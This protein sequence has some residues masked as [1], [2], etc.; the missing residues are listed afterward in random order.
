MESAQP[1]DVVRRLA[2]EAGTVFPSLAELDGVARV[3]QPVEQLLSAAYFDTDDLD[4]ARHGVTLRRRTGGT[5][6][7]WLLRLPAGQGAPLDLRRP[8]GR[9]TTTVPT[10]LASAVRALVRGRRLA[11]VA[12]VSTRR[13]AYDLVT[14]DAVV[15]A[16]VSDDQ[17][18][19]ERLHGPTQSEDWREWRVQPVDGHRDLVDLV[20]RRLLGVGAAPA[21]AASRLARA[22]GDAIPA[23]PPPPSRKKL[24]AGSAAGVMLAYLTEHIGELQRHDIGLRAE[25]GTAVHQLRIA[26]RRIRSTLQTYGPLV[27]SRSVDPIID[28]LRWLGQSLSETRDAQVLGQRLSDLA[29][30]EPAE[31][32][33]GPV[34]RRIDDELRTAERTGLEHGLETLDSDRYVRLLDA[35]DALVASP[36]LASAAEAPA[37]KVLPDLLQREGKRLRRAVKRIA[38]AT[39]PDLH[40]AALHEARKKAKRLRYAAESAAPVFGKRAEALAAAVKDVQDA[41]GEHQDAVMA[42][43]RLREYGVR[44][45]AAGENGFTFGRLHALEQARA[46]EAERAFDA[47]WRAMPGGNLRRWIGT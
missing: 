29:A 35:L 23:P 2:V 13:L 5:D 39:D 25:G 22:L 14:E 17:V 44:A 38:A 20:E 24:S 11:P 12:R 1:D 33:L 4:L 31:L 36:P 41:L 30:R 46:E 8:A 42:R 19:A 26:A 27:R 10:E 16:T 45:H 18:H 47:A 43:Q 3:S 28:D 7:G 9:A 32:V 21:P 34:P 37:R 6:A 15:L 40:D